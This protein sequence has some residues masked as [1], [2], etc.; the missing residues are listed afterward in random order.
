MTNKYTNLAKSPEL[1]QKVLSLIEKSFDYS[2]ENSFAT[3]FYPLMNPNNHSNCHIILEGNNPIAHIGVLNAAIEIKNKLF[4][5]AMYGGIAVDKHHRGKGLFRDLF[6][7]IY[8]QYHCAL[9]ILWSDQIDLYKRMGFYPAINLYSY[10][11]LEKK[12]KNTEQLRIVKTKL[13]Q[14]KTEEL[15]QIF[16]LYNKPNEARIKR[17]ANDWNVLKKITSADLYLIKHNHDKVINY[18]IIN[19]GQDLAGIIHEYGTVDNES[20]QVLRQFG[21]VWS[22][23]MFKD[24]QPQALYA[25]LVKIGDHTKFRDLV[26]HYCEF[27]IQK[28]TDQAIHFNFKDESFSLPI[29]EFLTGIFGPNRLEEIHA[30]YLYIPGLNSI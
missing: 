9:H 3:D 29:D 12:F 16:K 5:I 10:S 8:P 27:N 18:F 15:S 19:K 1:E 13:N 28:I 21:Q 30:P 4:S 24:H 11:M 20:I 14:L 7:H 26:S 2:T 23:Q 17:D 22:T 6:N 25:A